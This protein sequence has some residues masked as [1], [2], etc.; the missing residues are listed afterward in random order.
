M[1]TR[2]CTLRGLPTD[3]PLKNAPFRR[4]GWSNAFSMYTWGRRTTLPAV[5]AYG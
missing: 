2:N 1:L 3:A 4:Y 5:N